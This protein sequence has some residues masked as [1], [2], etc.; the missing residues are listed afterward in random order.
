MQART[1]QRWQTINL[2]GTGPLLTV[3]AARWASQVSRFI[4]PS[5]AAEPVAAREPVGV[6]Q[7]TVR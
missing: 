5:P 6:P 2:S 3:Q 4:T 7:R 1:S